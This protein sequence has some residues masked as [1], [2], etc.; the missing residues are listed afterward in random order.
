MR[1]NKKIIFLDVDGTLTQRDGRV[2]ELVQQGIKDARKNG[3]LVFLCTGRNKSGVKSLLDI[4]FDGIVCS[5]GGYIEIGGKK[6]YDAF[7]PEEDVQE[8]RNIFSRN[9]VHYNLEAT[10]C[11]YQDDEMNKLFVKHH[12]IDEENMNSEMIRLMNEQKER[13]NIKDLLLYDQNPKPIHK[14]CFIALDENDLEEPKKLLS[15][16]YTF[17]IHTMFSG[18]T[19]NGEIIMKNMSKGDA[20]RK[21]VEHLGL[22]MDDTICFGDSMNDYEMVEACH[23]S[24]VMD[25]GDD[26][27]KAIAS[28]IC[29]S[30]EDDGIY[31]EMKR[32][33]LI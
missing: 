4:G 5:A 21:V 1:M 23:Y 30:V 7:I 14:I 17:I 29:E 27:L 24:V 10:T 33:K 18:E 32:L 12:D 25:N 19:T 6:I 13:F 8:A 15:E 9:H 2:N 20:V 28:A 16:K 31:H 11:T 3:H 22:S 26:E